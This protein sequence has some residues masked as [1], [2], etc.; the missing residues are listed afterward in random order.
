[1]RQKRNISLL[2]A[3]LLLASCAPAQVKSWQNVQD[4]PAGT[5]ISVKA[6]HRIRCVF[7]IATDQELVCEPPIPGQFMFP[8]SHQVRLERRSIHEVRRGRVDRGRPNK[9]DLIGA[10]IGAG[11]GVGIGSRCTTYCGNVTALLGILGAAFGA[12]IGHAVAQ[13]EVIYRQ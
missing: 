12:G 2:T 10:G 5:P 8:G 6:E 9:G 1:M 11:I 13:G 7:V 3:S 4:L